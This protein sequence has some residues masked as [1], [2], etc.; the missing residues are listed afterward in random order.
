M[1][2]PF[3][4]SPV[5][6][7]QRDLTMD[8]SRYFYMQILTCKCVPIVCLM[9]CSPRVHYEWTH[10]TSSL[11]KVFV[12]VYVHEDMQADIFYDI[13]APIYAAMHTYTYIRTCRPAYSTIL[14]RPC[15]QLCIHIHTYAH[16]GRHILRYCSAHVRSPEL[17]LDSLRLH[18]VPEGIV[19]LFYVCMYTYVCVCVG[20]D[21]KSFLCM[22]VYICMCVCRKGL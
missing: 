9:T 12:H 14:Q 15:M 11:F 2:W 4:C 20:R 1:A 18:F 6:Y 5:H 17:L 13:V 22:Y 19:S 10:R 7:G 21:C 16:A 8:S 3:I